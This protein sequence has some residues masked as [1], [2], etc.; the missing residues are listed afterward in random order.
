MIVKRDGRQRW[1][2]INALPIEEI[3]DRWIS[4]YAAGAVELRARM[5]REI[6]K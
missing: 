2:Y 1:N 5:K 3:H 6:E 4:P